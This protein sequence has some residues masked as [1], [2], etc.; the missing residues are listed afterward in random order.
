MARIIKQGPRLPEGYLEE[1]VEEFFRIY[2]YEEIAGEDLKQNVTQRNVE[3]ELV[4]RYF[5]NE[6]KGLNTTSKELARE[7]LESS[8]KKL[9]IYAENKMINFI[10]QNY[11]TY[12]YNDILS[13]IKDYVPTQKNL[14][15]GITTIKL[16]EANLQLSKFMSAYEEFINWLKQ[17]PANYKAITVIGN[18]FM[19]VEELFNKTNS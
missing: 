7:V 5:V 12:N 9:S 13:K 10:R 2:N 14:D 17:D 11:D 8:F 3:I 6:E 15:D 18:Y 4:H 1:A 19:G 16:V